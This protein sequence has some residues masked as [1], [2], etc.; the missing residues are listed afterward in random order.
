[1]STYGTGD[2]IPP[3]IDGSFEGIG[4]ATECTGFCLEA[5]GN[6]M[7]LKTN[8]TAVLL[9]FITVVSRTSVHQNQNMYLL[10]INTST[11]VFWQ[12]VVM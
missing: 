12:M 9:V 10:V 3:S 7:L 6:L 5:D 1:M 8:L 4:S 2:Y 11:L